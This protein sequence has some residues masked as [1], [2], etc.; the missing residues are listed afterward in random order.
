MS[1]WH[2]LDFF[3]PLDSMSEWYDYLDELKTTDRFKWTY[4]IE[5]HWGGVYTLKFRSE[6]DLFWFRLSHSVDNT[7]AMRIGGIRHIYPNIIAADII[8]GVPVTG[9]VAQIHTLRMRYK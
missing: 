5:G 6:K 9:P 4:R 7:N 2:K 1:K 8:G 3:E